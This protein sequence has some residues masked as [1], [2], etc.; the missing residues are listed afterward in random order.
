[1]KREH[2]AYL[3]T[4][5]II[6]SGPLWVCDHLPHLRVN[7]FIGVCEEYGIIITLAHF[8]PVNAEDL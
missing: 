4:T 6:S 5:R 7:N 2:I 3:R 1:M 8:A